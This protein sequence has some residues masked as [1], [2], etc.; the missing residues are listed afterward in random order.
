MIKYDKKGSYL[1]IASIESSSAD[2]GD[3]WEGKT[4]AINKIVNA[5]SDDVKDSI[6][7]SNTQLKL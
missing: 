5:R 1:Y 2:V 6:A 4:R 7:D 3:V